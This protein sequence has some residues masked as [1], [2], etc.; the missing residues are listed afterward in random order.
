MAGAMRRGKVGFDLNSA[1]ISGN[2][3]LNLT[4]RDAV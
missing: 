2:N 4:G 1:G 3:R